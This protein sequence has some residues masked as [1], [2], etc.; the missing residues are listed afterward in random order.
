MMLP[1]QRIF[2]FVKEFLKLKILVIKMISG[3]LYERINVL[4]NKIAVYFYTAVFYF[5]LQLFC[6]IK[7]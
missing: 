5:V 2:L 1:M 7:K 6:C 4:S 3:I